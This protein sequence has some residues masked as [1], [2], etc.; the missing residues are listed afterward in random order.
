MQY[1]LCTRGALCA[2]ALKEHDCVSLEEG[3]EHEACAQRLAVRFPLSAF[4]HVR[5]HTE[6][7]IEFQCRIQIL[8]GAL[9]LRELHACI[10]AMPITDRL[11]GTQLQLTIEIFNRLGSVCATHVHAA[12]QQMMELKQ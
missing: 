7:G 10:T 8:Q 6:F 9:I 11:L 4:L 5:G 12:T 2:C 3:R 1:G